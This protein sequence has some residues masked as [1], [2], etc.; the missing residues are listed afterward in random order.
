P[1]AN[2]RD[3][4][5]VV[6][7]TIEEHANDTTPQDGNDTH[8]CNQLD[9]GK[10]LLHFLHAPLGFKGKDFFC[11]LVAPP[12][13]FDTAFFPISSRSFNSSRRSQE[14]SVQFIKVQYLSGTSMLRKE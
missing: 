10:S 13:N 5:T 8:H 11:H 9:K 12:L 1:S 14:R 3:R 6:A 2:H 4:P 7:R